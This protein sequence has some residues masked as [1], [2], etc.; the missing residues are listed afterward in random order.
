[1]E[2]LTL[3]TLE[4]SLSE[5]FDSSAGN[6][7]TAFEYYCNEIEPDAPWFDYHGR[8]IKIPKQKLLVTICTADTIGTTRSQRLFWVLF[9]SGLNVSMI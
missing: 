2:E 7:S 3:A 5:Y 4:V 6:A 8:K 9:D 1:M